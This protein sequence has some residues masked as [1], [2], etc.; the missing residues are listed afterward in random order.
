VEWLKWLKRHKSLSS[1]P[2]TGREKKKDMRFFRALVAHTCNPS[3]S[4][5]RDEENEGSKPAQANSSRDP[6]LKN[7]VTKNWAGG[8]AQSEG[9]EFK[10]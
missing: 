5:V 3:Y 7:P 2:Y 4:G 10:P 6:I 9:P 8:V 1:N